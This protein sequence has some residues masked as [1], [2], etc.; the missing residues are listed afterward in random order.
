[1]GAAACDAAV[2]ELTR[3]LDQVEEPLKQTFQNVHQGYPTDT[4]VRFLKAREWHVSKA[5]DMLVDSLNWRIQNEIDSILEKPIIP[6]DLYRSIRETQ[7]VG[8]SG[9]SKEV[10]IS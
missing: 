6:V 5:C 9:Y 7:L 10:Q 4:L 3:L 1:M 2:E 8:L